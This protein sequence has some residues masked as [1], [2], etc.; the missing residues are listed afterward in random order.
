LAREALALYQKQQPDDT[1]RFLAESALGASLAGQKK[2]AEGEPLLIEGHQGSE[3]RKDRIGIPFRYQVDLAREWLVQMYVE[4][5]K[6]EKAAESRKK[7]NG[8]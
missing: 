1:N 8:K 5:G 2:Y 3:A 7:Q 6:P 4:W